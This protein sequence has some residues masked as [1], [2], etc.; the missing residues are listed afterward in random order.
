MREV[1]NVGKY[2]S[3]DESNLVELL[4]VL[5]VES[6][7]CVETLA[8]LKGISCHSFGCCA[9]FSRTP[10]FTSGSVHFVQRSG[11]REVLD[12]GGFALLGSPGLDLA[13][14]VDGRTT[15]DC[16]TPDVDLNSVLVASTASTDQTTEVAG[17]LGCS[18]TRMEG[19]DW[20]VVHC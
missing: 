6:F 17:M 7:A 5:F 8:T 12:T 14:W 11:H 13:S 16:D 1:V 9:G 2:S 18:C 4:F 19:A 20:Q 15:Q 3:D 10:L